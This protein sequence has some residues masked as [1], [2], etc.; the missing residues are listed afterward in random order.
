M[1]DRPL[2]WLLRTEAQCACYSPRVDFAEKHDVQT[3]DERTDSFTR[4]QLSAKAVIGGPL[5]QRAMLTFELLC[6]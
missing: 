4:P 3:L 1:P 5:K 2:L 6:G